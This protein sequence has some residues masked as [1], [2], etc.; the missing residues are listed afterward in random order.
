MIKMLADHKSPQLFAAVLKTCNVKVDYAALASEMG[1]G[2]SDA[3][4]FLASIT[5]NPKNAP[6]MRSP[7]AFQT[8][9][10]APRVLIPLQQTVTPR[11]RQPRPLRKPAKQP[12]PNRRRRL[13]PRRLP[14]LQ[15]AP[16][17]KARPARLRMRT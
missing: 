6:R 5:K 15:P 10:P 3:T 13:T 11:P 4:S 1:S 14:S 7:I 12:S 16:S 9:V 8:F 17:V 2:K